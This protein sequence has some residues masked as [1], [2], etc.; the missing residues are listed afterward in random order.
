[1]VERIEGLLKQGKVCS[2]ASALANTVGTDILSDKEFKRL[3]KKIKFAKK[4]IC[5]CSN[6]PTSCGRNTSRRGNPNNGHQ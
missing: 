6:F 2:A 4:S 3:E 1:M 5:K